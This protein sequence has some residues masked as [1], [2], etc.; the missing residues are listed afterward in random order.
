MISVITIKAIRDISKITIVVFLL[1]AC[2]YISLK[3]LILIYSV[4]L[5][6]I[7]LSVISPAISFIYKVPSDWIGPKPAMILFKKFAH[8][9]LE[10]IESLDEYELENAIQSYV[11][12]VKI[13]NRHFSQSP[14]LLHQYP[15]ISEIFQQANVS[16]K[17]FQEL[18]EI[19]K[20]K[21]EEQQES[22]RQ[23]R[24][25]EEEIKKRQKESYWQ[26]VLQERKK[27][28][29]NHGVPPVSL[30]SCPLEYPIRVTDNM[31]EAGARGIYYLPHERKGVEVYWCFANPEEAEAER[32]RRPFKT[33]PKRQNR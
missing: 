14:D 4:L 28:G 12:A 26:N 18:Q 11:S 16:I 10:Q 22:V 15:E 33:P 6:G 20:Q 7:I 25:R 8:D 31:K 30:Y 9:N 21:R 17:K 5:I 29:L 19:K 32:F 13:I 24:L 3:Q 27:R 2:G 1:W 23:Q